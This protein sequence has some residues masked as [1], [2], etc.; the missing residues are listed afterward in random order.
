MR[1][2]TSRDKR[3]SIDI[4]QRA[5]R[6]IPGI[7]WIVKKDKKIEKR[8][9]HL[10]SFCFDTA[11]A[12]NGVHIT[13]DNK[14]VGLMYRMKDKKFRLYDFVL[15]LKLV[16]QVI[17]VSRLDEIIIRE[18][19]IK[20]HRLKGDYLYFWMVAVDPNSKG[21]EPMKEMTYW[22]IDKSKEL[23]IP[24]LAETSV[25]QNR[26]VYER[27]GYKVYHTWN[28]PDKDFNFYF[29]VRYPNV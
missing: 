12:A 10:C 7:L 4:L 25:E 5:F 18:R 14:G 11:L 19:Y 20:T 13:S 8:I 1:L 26:R 27:Y 15:Y 23:N 6:N 17:G 9:K 28:V 3:F 24:I 2:A 22:S 16:F 29:M 21:I